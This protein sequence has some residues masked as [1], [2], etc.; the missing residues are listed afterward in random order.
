MAETP[1]QIS[2]KKARQMALKY[3]P[4][5]TKAERDEQLRRAWQN[6]AIQKAIIDLVTNNAP[7]HIIHGLI[8]NYRNGVL[9]PS[10]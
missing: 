1:I 3:G 8:L 4:D 2:R 10:K 7:T 6:P 5:D 9:E